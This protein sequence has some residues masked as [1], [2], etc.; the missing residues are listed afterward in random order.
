MKI[1]PAAVAM[2]V[3]STT[4]GADPDRKASTACPTGAQLVELAHRA[5]ADAPERVAAKLDPE[6]LACRVLHARRST[7]LTASVEPPTWPARREQRSSRLTCVRQ[8]H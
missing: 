8:G 1:A 6:Q 5:F 2:A 7:W 4:A 3:M